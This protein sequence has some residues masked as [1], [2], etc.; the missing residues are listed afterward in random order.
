MSVLRLIQT[1]TLCFRCLWFTAG[2]LRREKGLKKVLYKIYTPFLITWENCPPLF[3][4]TLLCVSVLALCFFGNWY[5]Q[6]KLYW[7]IYIFLSVVLGAKVSHCWFTLK[8]FWKNERCNQCC[9]LGKKITS[10]TNIMLNGRS[11]E[12]CILLSVG[13]SN[14]AVASCCLLSVTWGQGS[15]LV[16]KAFPAK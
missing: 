3:S 1:V 8:L 4:E 9:W 10:V 11:C 15:C 6:E 12:M 14:L 7:K 5:F 13:L 2:H 16:K